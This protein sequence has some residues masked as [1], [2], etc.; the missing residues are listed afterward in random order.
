MPRVVQQRGKAKLRVKSR[1]LFVNR[2]D[3]H[4]EDSERLGS[5]QS[6]LESIVEQCLSQA[7]ALRPSVDGQASTKIM[8]TGCRGNFMAISGGML[9]NDTALAAKV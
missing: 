9:S 6:S 5:A 1:G 8:G 7:L 2:E 4:G 3:F